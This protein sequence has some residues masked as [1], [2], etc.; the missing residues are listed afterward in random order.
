MN[1]R[2][3]NSFVVLAEKGNYAN[4]AESL[5]VS[6]PALTKQ[7]NLLES[8]TNL[9]L[10]S[11]GRHGTTLTAEGERLLP[12][13]LKALGYID[14]FLQHA[15]RIAKG[16]EGKLT[17]GFG[18]SSFHSAPGYIAQ[19][20]ARYPDVD[21]SLEDLPSA[22]QYAW[23]QAGQLDV[24]FVRLPPVQSLSFH[25]LFEDRLVLVT[26]GSSNM[27]TQ[28]W[29][30]TLPLLR[31]YPQRGSGLNSQT[32]LFLYSSKLSVSSTQQVEDIQTIVALI[33]AGLGIALLPE[34]VRYIAP[35]H[36]NVIAQTGK[37]SC[38]QVGIAWEPTIPNL[39]RDN[40]IQLIKEKGEYST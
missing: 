6:Q 31:L 29:L 9:S 12:E 21:I 11:R 24:G 30:N 27:S 3:L 2:L 20:R 5:S 32:E 7:I 15:D 37:E 40:F 18:L 38:W 8:I 33:L 17:V 28:Q 16:Q 1:T 39:I 14:S 4:A 19:F 13:A 23:L 10:F 25:P 34:S 35:P 22:Q 26:P 36:L